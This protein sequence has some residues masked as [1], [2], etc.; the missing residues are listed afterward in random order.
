MDGRRLRKTDL[1]VKDNV[2]ASQVQELSSEKE[3]V[4]GR[5]CVRINGKLITTVTK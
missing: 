5:F 1:R 3:K 4:Q 2:Q